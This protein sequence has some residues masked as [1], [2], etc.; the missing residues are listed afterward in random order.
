MDAYTVVVKIIVERS[1]ENMEA[2]LRT[3]LADLPDEAIVLE[4][5]VFP[6][7]VEAKGKVAQSSIK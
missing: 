1:G 2:A 6:S 7:R 5:M 3:A 4:A